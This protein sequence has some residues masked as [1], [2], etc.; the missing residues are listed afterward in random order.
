MRKPDRFQ[1]A[2]PQVVGQPRTLVGHR[3]HAQH[4]RSAVGL[5]APAV[6]VAVEVAVQV[7]QGLGARRVVFAHLALVGRVVARGEGRDR[8]L[9]RNAVAT[10]DMADVGVAVVGQA[11]GAP[12]RHLVWRVAADQRVLHE[13]EAHAHVGLQAALQAH[14][15]LLQERRQFAVRRGNRHIGPGQGQERIVA[16]EERQPARLVFFDDVDDHLVDQRQAAPLQAGGDRLRQRLVGR[17]ALVV[18]LAVARRAF[19]LDARG[20]APALEPEGA[21][22][23]RMGADVAAVELDHLARHR[24]HD[25]RVG[26]AVEEARVGARP[27]SGCS[28]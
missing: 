1:I 11:D 18:T 24:A 23:H 19:Q 28:V 16:V 27:A 4:E 15:L 26:E 10:E 9:R 25:H 6:V 8:R 3:R 17:R 7:Q 20:A 21:G 14:A 12:Q 5:F 22:A 2:P 13:E